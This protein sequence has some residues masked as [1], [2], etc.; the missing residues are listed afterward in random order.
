[1]GE[2]QI[3]SLAWDVVTLKGRGQS[4]G[5]VQEALGPRGLELWRVSQRG[6]FGI[7]SSHTERV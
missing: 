6:Q 2:G 4:G 1:M 3:T 7:I 5:G